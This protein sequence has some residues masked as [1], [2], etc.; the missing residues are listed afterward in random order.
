MTIIAEVINVTE[1]LKLENTHTSDVHIVREENDRTFFNQLKLFHFK[2]QHGVKVGNKYEFQIQLG[3]RK[4]KDNR[5]F[6][7]IKIV[8]YRLLNN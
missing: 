8:H 1:P 5:I 2:P 4:T 7:E 3:G 6:N